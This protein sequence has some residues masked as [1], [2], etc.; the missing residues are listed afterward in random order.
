VRRLIVN[1]DDFGLT[2]GVDQAVI[3]LHRARALTSA[4]LMATG[5]GFEQA[6]ALTK[7]SDSLG[8]GCHVV[9]VD[10]TPVLPPSEIPSLIDDSSPNGTSFRPKLSNFV[11]DLLRGRISDLEIEAEA[12]A[13]IRK[14]HDAEIHVTHID[15]HKHTHIFPRV[16]RPLLRAA[17][18]SGVKAIRNPFEP[19][20][21][22]GATANAG[23]VRKMQVRLL[24]SQAA[25]FSEEVNRAGLLTTEG[26]IGVLATGTLDTQ[27]IRNLLTSMPEGTWELVCH[28]GYNDAALQQQ[29]TRLLAS[30]EVE[31]TALLQT[32]PGASA[33]LIHFGQL[34]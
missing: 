22:L 34:S 8:V 20:W 5:A 11:T 2:Q 7:Q 16:L 10:G 18:A 29:R 24:R 26:A 25:A 21:S 3:E 31:R 4:T 23:H 27:T 9:L 32:I 28:P 15:T 17:L 14:L 19:N 6:V 12:N 33:E 13:Q 1:A 30:R